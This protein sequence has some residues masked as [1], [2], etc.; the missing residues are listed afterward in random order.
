MIADNFWLWMQI[1]ALAFFGSLAVSGF[2]ANAGL[3]DS[4]DGRSAHEGVVPTSGG[5][6][7]VAGLGLALCA[8]GI[9]FPS[10]DLPIRFAPVMALVFAIAMLG[11]VDDVLTLGAILKFGLMLIISGGAVLLIGP[12]EA[13]P[14]MFKPVPLP[15]WAGFLGATLWVF[16]VMNAVNF[17]DGANGMMALSLIIAN[18]GLFG[19]GLLVGSATTL[20]LSGL[21]LMTIFG[22]LPYNLRKK[23]KVFAGDIGS[24]SLSFLFAITVLFLIAETPDATYHLVGPVLIL[25]FLADVLLTMV[26]RLRAKDN[27]LQAHNKHLYQ[28]LI[29]HGFGHLKISW[30]YALGALIC[31]NIVVIGA[32]KGWFDRIDIS[33]MLIG[34]FSAI[35]F[36]ASRSLIDH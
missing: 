9:L 13:L 31:A 36:I 25:P 27:L 20:L 4:S 1:G 10:L 11:L 26:R 29:R 5:V 33:V 6:G 2:M 3:G 32:P 35:Y 15:F 16:V 22:F 21:S 12:P 7:I 23:A 24:L 34:A 28:R 18:F 14:F 19:V 17:M 30:F 8:L